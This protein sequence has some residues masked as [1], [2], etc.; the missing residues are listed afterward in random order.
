[1]SAETPWQQNNE[2]VC[3]LSTED[4]MLTVSS[5]KIIFT[6]FYLSVSF[7]CDFMWYSSVNICL[8][9]IF[10]LDLFCNI[11]YNGVA[12][13]ILRTS[14]FLALHGQKIECVGRPRQIKR[15][16]LSLLDGR[17]LRLDAGLGILQGPWSSPFPYWSWA[18][19]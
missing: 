12:V 13:V 7:L 9:S 6:E 19:P 14:K 1:M 8:V 11:V 3:Y 16:A 5:S 2:P 17:A 15:K 18:F 4:E 10:S